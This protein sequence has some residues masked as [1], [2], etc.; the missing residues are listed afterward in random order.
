MTNWP[1][2]PSIFGWLQ[3]IR[4]GHWLLRDESVKRPQLRAFITHNYHNDERDQWFFQKSPQKV[5]VSLNEQGAIL[6]ICEREPALFAN[7]DLG[8]LL[9]NIVPDEANRAPKILGFQPEPAP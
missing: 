2:G 4:Q 8:W 9:D 7:A 5:F 1:D 6:M 3:L